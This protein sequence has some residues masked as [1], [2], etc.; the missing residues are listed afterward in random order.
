LSEFKNVR[1]GGII[2]INLKPKDSLFTAALTDG[3]ND[4]IIGTKMGKAIR[5]KETKVRP[6]GRQAAGVKAITL[7][8]KD[9]VISMIVISPED[10]YIF[11]A[12]ELGY[13]KK[14]PI[15]DYPVHNRGGQGVINLKI[16]EKIGQ[17]LAMVGV[18]E[19]DLLIITVSGKVIRIKTTAI[20]PLSRATQGVRLIQLDPGDKICSIAKV[21]ED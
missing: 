7:K 15:E 8:P 5:F 12:S 13:G 21:R 1:K 16:T 2:A 4:I 9:R 10:K 14:T 3:K 20:R 11:T 17:A 6:M 18:N 19:D